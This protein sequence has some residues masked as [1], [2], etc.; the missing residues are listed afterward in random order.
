[1]S[2]AHRATSRL[3]DQG[4]LSVDLCDC[5][6]VHL[7]VSSLTLRIEVSSF[8]QLVDGLVLARARLL[9]QWRSGTRVMPGRSAEVA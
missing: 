7:H 4:A 5:G 3:V 2:H 1:M 6:A 8:L 9:Q